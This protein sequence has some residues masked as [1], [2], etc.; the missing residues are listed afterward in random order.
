MNWG[1]DDFLSQL[2]KDAV[3]VRKYLLLGLAELRY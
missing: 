2:I 3:R 1:Q